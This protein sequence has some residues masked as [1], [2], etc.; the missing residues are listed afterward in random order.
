MNGRVYDP[1]LGRFLSADPHI[2]S[3]YD[4]QSYNRYTYVKNNPLKYT[5]P[6]GFFFKKIKKYIKPIITIAVTIGVALATGGASLGA[7]LAS[8]AL[9]GFAGGVTGSLL[10]GGSFNNVLKAGLKGAFWGAV[11][12]GV[13]WGVAEVAA[14]VFNVGSDIAHKASLFEGGNVGLA[15]TKAAM[16]GLTRSAITKAQG[17]RWSSGF[18]S[19]FASSAFA[20]NSSW[21]K[22]LGTMVTAVVSGTVSSINGGKFA[23]GAVTGA[24]VHLFN[25]YAGYAKNEEGQSQRIKDNKDEYPNFIKFVDNGLNALDIGLS[26]I[27]GAVTAV[28]EAI[29]FRKVYNPVVLLLL[30]QQKKLNLLSP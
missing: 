6:S 2:Q 5:D 4:T 19:G 23:N 17:G 3:P 28:G 21:G 15:T 25:R 16:H 18:W 1:T 11:S 27:T 24:F 14:G 12:A 7:M 9:A 13:A 29:I 30:V 22:K 26:A 10:N 20:A 8:G